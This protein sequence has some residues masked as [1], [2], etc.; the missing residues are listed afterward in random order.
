[1]NISKQFSVSVFGLTQRDIGMLGRGLR[2]SNGRTRSYVMED[3]E[4][5]EA[6]IV[7]AD[8]ASL[9]ALPRLKPSQGLV[10]V[11]DRNAGSAG[12]RFSVKRPLLAPRVLEVFD[13]VVSEQLEFTPELMVGAVAESD[14]NFLHSEKDVL[15]KRVSGKVQSITI[16]PE[17]TTAEQ[18]QEISGKKVLV[19]DDSLIVRE[20]MK[21]ILGG[22]GASVT[23]CSSGEE[24]LRE[25]D[26]NDYDV[27]FLDV[28]MPGLSGFETCKELK[29]KKINDAKVVM[30]TSKGSPVSRVRGRLS[31]A[32]TYITKP[33]SADKLAR[34]I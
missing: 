9:D 7:I 21:L 32:N 22:L 19:V 11:S 27:I 26:R 13:R 17:E 6:D 28:I 3:I 33:A 25:V 31:G 5:E 29:N 23:T 20:Q 16:N 4:V 18:G 24:A 30:L 34:F 8:A 10:V 14:I 15:K 12:Q 1:M 2:L